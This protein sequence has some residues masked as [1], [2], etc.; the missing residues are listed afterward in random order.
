MHSEVR[1]GFVNQPVIRIRQGR[2]GRKNDGIRRRQN[3]A[4]AWLLRDLKAAAENLVI[5]TDSGN[6]PQRS[7]LE[8]ENRRRI[9]G[10]E[11]MRRR[12]QAAKPFSVRQ[13]GGEIGRNVKKAKQRICCCHYDTV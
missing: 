5:Q 13:T 4:E 9:E 10:N 3:C 12:Q 11:P 1:A 2:V 7:A 6:R 8:L